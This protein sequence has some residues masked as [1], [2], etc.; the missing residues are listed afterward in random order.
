MEGKYSF[1]NDVIFS[2]NLS[3][4]LGVPRSLPLASPSPSVPSRPLRDHPRTR[5]IAGQAFYEVLR[6][7]ALRKLEREKRTVVPFAPVVA[8]DAN[9]GAV[10]DMRAPSNGG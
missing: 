2:E 3:G 6:L 4:R 10:D 7:K 8:E 9:G 1:S 5:T